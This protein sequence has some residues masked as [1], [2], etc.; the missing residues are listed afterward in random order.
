[1]F[2]ALVP[3]SLCLFGLFSPP[4]LGASGL[5]VWMLIFTVATRLSFTFYVVPWSAMFAELTDDYEERSA[6][7]A[8]RFAVGWI[9]G[10]VVLVVSFRFITTANI[11][12][13]NW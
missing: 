10:I 5:I 6:L 12:A 2:A 13:D 7:M 3:L 1:M 11:A 9:V 4:A 8:Y